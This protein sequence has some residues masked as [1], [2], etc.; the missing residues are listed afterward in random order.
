MILRHF[1]FGILFTSLLFSCSLDES[2]DREL[3][4][5]YA[6]QRIA[7]KDSL[8]NYI[9]LLKEG[10]VEERSAIAFAVGQTGDSAFTDQLV[11]SF[12]ATDTSGTF[13]LSNGTILEALGKIADVSTLH[14]LATISTYQPHDTLLLLGRARSLYRFALRGLVDSLGTD[15]MVQYA[16]DA[17]YPSSVQMIAAQYLARPNQ[18]QIQGYEAPVI[19]AIYETKVPAVKMALVAALRKSPSEASLETLTHILSDTLED[20]R[21]VVN[22]TRALAGFDALIASPIWIQ[23]LNHPNRSVRH[24]VAEQLIPNGNPQDAL[25]YYN[26]AKIESDPP[27][28]ILLFQAAL[29]HLPAFY[30]VTR[31]AARWQIQQLFRQYQE[32]AVTRAAAMRALSKADSTVAFIVQLGFSDPSPLVKKAAVEAIRSFPEGVALPHLEEALKNGTPGMIY[33]VVQFLQSNEGQYPTLVDQLPQVLKML[34]IPE[35]LETAVMVGQILD[36]PTI[37]TEAFYRPIHDKDVA[38]DRALIRTNKGNIV[39]QLL[40]EYAPVTVSAFKNLIEEDFYVGLTF[41][42]VVPNFVIQGGCPVGDGL[43]GP[44]FLLPTENGTI[45]YDRPG[46]VGMASAGRDTEGSQFFITHSPTPHL[47]GNYTIFAT[48]LEGMEIVH[49]I[50]EGDLIE[51]IELL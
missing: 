13:A 10:T 18:V 21:I 22:A 46:R 6:L 43:A 27:I 2:V 44:N 20:Y 38:S 40:P 9:H 35:Q 5:T 14:Q 30:T 41:H 29:T 49:A 11:Q 36:R 25:A 23:V 1:T 19:H 31:S 28:K 34:S 48:V 39:I 24:T 15:V 33:E 32:D 50:Q 3:D 45:Y 4:Q 12:V 26:A 51:A 8:A 17:Q 16:T 47:D 42:R 7:N 37:P